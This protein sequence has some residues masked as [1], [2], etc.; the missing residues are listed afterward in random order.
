MKVK[1]PWKELELDKYFHDESRQ[2]RNDNVDD[3]NVSH[4]HA[5][6]CRVFRFAL[7]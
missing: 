1:N 2:I 4:A 3:D 6:S 7:L 5:V